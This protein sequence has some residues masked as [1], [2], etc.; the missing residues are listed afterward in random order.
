M[1][2]AASPM[3]ASGAGGVDERDGATVYPPP[4]GAAAGALVQV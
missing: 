4:E 2:A 3:A 1:A